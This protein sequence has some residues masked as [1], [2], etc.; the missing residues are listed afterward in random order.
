MRCDRSLYHAIDRRSR[1]LSEM[2]QEQGKCIDRLDPVGPWRLI[3]QPAGPVLGALSD[4]QTP[5]RGPEVTEIE[6]IVSVNPTN[7]ADIQ[8]RELLVNASDFSRKFVTDP[9]QRLSGPAQF[10][11]H[12]VQFR[13]RL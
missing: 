4:M 1:C 7:Q 6:M 11:K 3:H 8:R 9:V 12:F 2:K 5:R 10:V 13:Q